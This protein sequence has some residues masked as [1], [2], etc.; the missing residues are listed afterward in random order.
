LDIV[1]LSKQQQKFDKVELVWC[2]RLTEYS[3]CGPLEYDTYSL[4]PHIL[5]QR[6]SSFFRAVETS[7]S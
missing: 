4:F 1:K 5:Q 2:F 6:I 3:Y 7:H